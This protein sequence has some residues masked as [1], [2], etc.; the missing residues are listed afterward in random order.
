MARDLVRPGVIP[1]ED[2]EAVSLF[3][4]AED[5][6][7]LDTDAATKGSEI[8]P[9]PE[10][11]RKFRHSSNTVV[12]RSQLD[13]TPPGRVVPTEEV[14]PRRH[15]H[16]S[17]QLRTCH[18]RSRCSARVCADTDDGHLMPRV[19]QRMAPLYEKRTSELEWIQYVR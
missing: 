17:L 12:V 14:G 9:N 13:I 15:I 19:W 18:P 5:G 3:G 6:D 2:E 11:V 10:L 8:P 16:R 1:D 4:T 7:S